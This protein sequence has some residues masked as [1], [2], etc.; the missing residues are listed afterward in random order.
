MAGYSY[1]PFA[2]VIF[3]FR[4]LRRDP[5]SHNRAALSLHLWYCGGVLVCL[6][7]AS[8]D[9]PSRSII[10]MLMVNSL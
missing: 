2:N 7:S 8:W 3:N 5:L 4:L 6:S 9:F 1:P 10:T